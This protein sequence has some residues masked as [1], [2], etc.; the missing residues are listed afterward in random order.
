MLRG[1]CF[2]RVMYYRR[3]T[4]LSRCVNG[5]RKII[6]FNTVI[7]TDRHLDRLLNI[8]SHLTFI[9][10]HIKFRKIASKNPT[11]LLGHGQFCYVPF[12]LLKWIKYSA[13]RLTDSLFQVLV[14]PLLLY[15]NFGIVNITVNKAGVV[16][17]YLLLKCNEF[18]GVF[19]AEAKAKRI[20][21]RLIRSLYLSNERQILLP[22]FP[23]RKQ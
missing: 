16:E 22:L 6:Y 11:R 21:L 1:L 3:L 4:E 14:K 8:H 12:G 13:I 17:V 9:I 23:V 19:H 20:D 18:F 10:I 5:H 7:L 15:H 2:C